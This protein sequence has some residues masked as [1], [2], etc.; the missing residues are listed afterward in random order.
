VCNYI[1]ISDRKFI[2]ADIYSDSM[3]RHKYEFT[4]DLISD[5]ETRAIEA[6]INYAS[7]TINDIVD[8]T[9]KIL[10]EKNIVI[11]FINLFYIPYRKDVYKKE[12][13]IHAV[14]VCGYNLQKQVFYVLDQKN[15]FSMTFTIWEISFENIIQATETLGEFVNNYKN[16]DLSYIYKTMG[17]CSSYKRSNDQPVNVNINHEMVINAKKY[18]HILMKEYDDFLNIIQLIGKEKTKIKEV[19]RIINTIIIRKKAE[20]YLLQN[21]PC[22]NEYYI[23]N[24][25]EILKN[26][27]ILK[28]SI[29]KKDIEIEKI[30]LITLKIIDLD[31]NW[32]KNIH[33]II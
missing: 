20:I 5:I 30:V 3:Y 24:N 14:V 27:Q 26:M 2:A 33:K 21:N 18:S 6:G 7:I 23:E 4:E 25:H 22:L 31:K 10:D 15:Y 19:I 9:L 29:L 28:N 1:G 17:V 8:N 12:N 13:S 11:L 16:C 32:Y